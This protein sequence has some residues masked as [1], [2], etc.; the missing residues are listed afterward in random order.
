MPTHEHA[1]T[2]QEQ[3]DH[4]SHKPVAL[5]NGEVDNPAHGLIPETVQA[6]VEPLPEGTGLFFMVFQRLGQVVQLA[7]FF[8]TAGSYIT[9]PLPGEQSDNYL[10]GF[11][12]GVRLYYKDRFTFRFDLAFPVD[13]QE[14]IGEDHY[15]YF[16]GSFNF[17]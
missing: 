2:E 1:D 17:F 11:G 16:Q 5:M 7:L 9:D 12:G 13:K 14:D 3:G 10:H 4:P 15:L 6:G 8:D